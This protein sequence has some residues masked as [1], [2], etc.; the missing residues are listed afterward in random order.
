MSAAAR[1]VVPLRNPAA[2]ADAGIPSGD[3]AITASEDDDL[4]Q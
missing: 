2:P 4:G 3:E 1:N